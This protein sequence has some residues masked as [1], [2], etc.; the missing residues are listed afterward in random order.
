MIKSKLFL[1]SLITVIGAMAVFVL[2]AAI[3]VESIADAQKQT[4]EFLL[5]WGGVAPDG[6]H[7]AVAISIGGSAGYALL[8]ALA[9]TLDALA[10]A[11]IH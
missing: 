4:M 1:F 6:L 2:V 9:L 11:S 3:F 10:D 7:K 5:G 8:V